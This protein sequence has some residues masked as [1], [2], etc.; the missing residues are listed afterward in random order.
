LAPEVLEMV[1]NKFYPITDLFEALIKNGRRVG[2]FE[3]FDDWID[4]GQKEQ[5]AEAKGLV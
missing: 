2:I 4:V 5:L 3:I 1:P